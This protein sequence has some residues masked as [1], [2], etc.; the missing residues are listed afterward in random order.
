MAVGMGMDAISISLLRSLLFA[1][2]HP[3]FLQIAKGTSFSILHFFLPQFFIPAL[4]TNIP[5]S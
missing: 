5:F 1:P 4:H 3:L 2:I